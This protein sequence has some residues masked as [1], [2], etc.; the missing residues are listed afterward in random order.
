MTEALLLFNGLV[1]GLI[2]AL[3]SVGLNLIYGV[4]G[5]INVAHGAFYML[6]AVLGWF[7][8]QQTGFWAAVLLAPLLVAVF[9]VAIERFTLRP[10]LNQ[11]V[12]TILATFA[13]M[14]IVQQ[15][16][17]LSPFGPAIQ[18]LEAP[19]RQ[20]LWVGGVPYSGYRLLV[21]L[22][23]LLVIALVWLF[24][25]HTR[26][27]L[28]VRAVKQNPELA[29]GLGIPVPLVY[30]LTF[31]LGTGLA[32]LAGVLTGP[33]GSVHALMGTDLLIL[34][35]LVVI[36]GGAGHLGGAVL[37]ALLARVGEGALSLW[38]QPTEA[39]LLTL[40]L[41]GMLVVLRP[42]GVFGGSA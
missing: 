11:P 2:V 34:A 39:K 17:I 3:M 13:W 29:L 32:A 8:A 5:V 26:Y 24:L 15:G 19:F 25:A 10:L 23:A 9:G 12:M 4:L 30:S 38:M 40:L 35:F 20:T 28:W 6:G 42:N 18:R 16:V 21:A 22:A 37:V 36:A 41:L 1:W 27:G 31:G 7:I 14:L 33:L